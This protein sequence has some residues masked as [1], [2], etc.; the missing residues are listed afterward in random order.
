V[1]LVVFTTAS[2][3]VQSIPLLRLADVR[4]FFPSCVAI[5][6]KPLFG[7]LPTGIF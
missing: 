5:V 4:L 6:K 7:V 2:A 1:N 3:P